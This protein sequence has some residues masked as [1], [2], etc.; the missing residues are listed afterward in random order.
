MH[1]LDARTYV[2]QIAEGVDVQYIGEAGGE[3]QVLKEAR[4]H[5]PGI[6]LSKGVS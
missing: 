1:V 4:E 2:M 3:T 5:M 6:A